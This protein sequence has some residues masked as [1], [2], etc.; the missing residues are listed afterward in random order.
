MK[1]SPK[2]GLCE[3]FKCAKT[4]NMLNECGVRVEDHM[5]PFQ[6]VQGFWVCGT[7]ICKSG[8]MSTLK[9][10]SRGNLAGAEN[11]LNLFTLLYL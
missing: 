10:C 2:S 7:V 1:M 11:G 5:K 9:N 4:L 6:C 8:L 3:T